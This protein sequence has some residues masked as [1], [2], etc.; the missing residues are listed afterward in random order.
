MKAKLI[1]L[2][3]ILCCWSLY[4]EDRV[5]LPKLII[6]GD[7]NYPPYE[8][9][10]EN[11]EADG[12]NVALSREIC[13]RLGYE[14]EFRLAKWSLVRSWLEDGSIDLVQGMAYSLGRAQDISFSIAHTTTWRAIF[15]GKNSKISNLQDERDITVVVQKDDVATDYLRQIKYPGRISEVS[16]QEEAL[17]LL[18]DGIFQA[19]VTNYM[20]SMYIIDRDN[21]N[22]IKALPQRIYQR[23]YCFASKDKE[24]IDKVDQALQEISRSSQLQDLQ[25][26]WFTSLDSGIFKAAKSSKLSWMITMLLCLGLIILLL[27]VSQ[28]RRQLNKQNMLLEEQ[29]RQIKELEQEL[30]G[31]RSS[32][33]RG[34]V[35]LYKMDFKKKMLLSISENVSAWGYDARAIISAPESY[36]QL[37]YSEDRPRLQEYM[38]KVQLNTP[39][40]IQYRVLTKAG[41]LR[42]V[43]DY[44]RVLRDERDGGTYVYGYNIDISDQKNLEAQLLEA[45][46]K[47]ESANIAKGHFLANMSH[48]LRTPLNGINGFLQVLMQM[49]ASDE[50]REIFDL[51]YSSGKNLMKIINDILDFSKIEAGKM[52]LIPSEFNPKYLIEDMVKQFSMQ[53]RKHNLEI[54]SNI[55][56]SLPDVLKGDQLRLQQIL[57]NL[58]QNAMKFTDNG[59]IEIGAELY[60]ISDKDIRILF[61]VAD[62]GMGIEPV[63]LKDIF[64]NYTQAESS[65]SLKYGG[66]GLGL[67][68]VKKLV[69]M[70]QGFI[71]VESELGKGSCFFFI[72][73]FQLYTEVEGRDDLQVMP[74][75]TAMERLTGRVLVVE[76]DNINKLVTKRQLELWG[77]EVDVAEN[78]EEAVRLHT[79]RPY[80]LILMDIQLPVMDGMTATRKIRELGNYENRK[81]PIIAYTAA[82]L[83]GDRERFLEYGMDE[84]IAK[85]V[86]MEELYNLVSRYLKKL[87]D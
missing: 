68:I 23:D 11:G 85:P 49:R 41:E 84:Y 80:N 19:C 64:D 17:K 71:W 31:Y 73:P 58:M 38:Q 72:L 18:N 30:K 55:G 20:M 66:T 54:R 61:R 16:T 59:H 25:D 35:L 15:V 87:G 37:V 45:K 60:T 39:N 13:K 86:D 67:A 43:L 44:S 36:L 8:F 1:V 33:D 83:M 4:A 40:L 2:C 47:A 70:M 50:Q 6:G 77:L 46:E 79:L 10:N 34:P 57:Q 76:D 82:A 52:E 7:Y 78:G 65:I 62:T 48:E 9:I 5:E 32:F 69:E 12:Y 22:K 75:L 14:P 53:N 74:V 26:T 63:K 24:L 42:W 51:M 29:V 27:I 81:T 28:K 3:L 21:L 56:N